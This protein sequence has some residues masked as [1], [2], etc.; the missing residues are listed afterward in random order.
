MGVASPMKKLFKLGKYPIYWA[1]KGFM[2]QGLWTW[3]GKRNVRLV[4]LNKFKNW[5][6][7]NI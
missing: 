7:K 4:A 5:T 3:N 6:G 1:G 2:Y